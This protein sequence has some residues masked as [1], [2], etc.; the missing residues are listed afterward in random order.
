MAELKTTTI[1]NDL[2]VSG[3]LS[4]TGLSVDSLWAKNSMITLKPDIQLEG[5]RGIHISPNNTLSIVGYP[6]SKIKIS[7]GEVNLE[8]SLVKLPGAPYIGGVSLQDFVVSTGTSGI[9]TYRKWHS[10]QI[11]LFGTYYTNNLQVDNSARGAYYAM[12]TIDLPT[13][14]LATAVYTSTITANCNPG[15]VYCAYANH[16]LNNIVVIPVSAISLTCK[17][18]FDIHIHGRW[19]T[20]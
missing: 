17:C 14:I 11:D 15:F 6:T 1:N 5:D 4:T 8:T 9:W 18:N 10:G 12:I 19:K 3:N 16:N 13:N 2:T 7:L 20:I